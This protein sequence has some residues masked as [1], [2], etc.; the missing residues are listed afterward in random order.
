MQFDITSSP[1]TVSA[2]NPQAYSR[3]N[4]VRLKDISIVSPNGTD[5]SIMNQY[6]I[7]QI[8]EDIFQNNLSGVVSNIDASNIVVNFPLTGEE[9]LMI[10]FETPGSGD[11]IELA[12]IIDKILDRAPLRNNQSQFYDIHFVCPTFTCNLF[13]DV[14]KAYNTTI[15]SMVSDIFKNNINAGGA[16]STRKELKTNEKTFGEQNVIIPSW[17]AFTSINWLSRRAVSETNQKICDYVFYQDLDGF[18]FRSISSMFDGE[19]MQTYIYGVDNSIDFVRDTPNS[20]IDMQKSFQN[21]RKLAAGG[22]DRSKETMKGAYASS[23]LV[24]DMVTKSYDETDYKYLDD[25][26]QKPS[27]NGNPIMPKNHMYS[28]KTNARGH[29]VPSHLNLYGEPS[30]SEE[31]SGNDGVEIWLPR[32]EAQLCMLQS[33]HI[34]IEVAGDSS[35]RVGD[36]VFALVN[37]FEGVDEQGR[38]KNDT[39]A[40]GNYIITRITHTIHKTVGHTMQMQ[41]CKE[42]NMNSTPQNLSFD[43]NVLPSGTGNILS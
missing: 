17:N 38:V 40:T 22:F 12:F 18:H 1:N 23:V 36:K 15:S 8:H 3:L 27:L 14:S 21:I 32:H 28:D 9:F 19:P 11:T 10:T 4:D 41:L 26:D 34:E 43:S 33:S 6:A 2:S 39:S 42:S 5:M 25:F 13:S 35:R 16:D 31:N 37:S 24:H 30:Q 29:F 20:E 7:L